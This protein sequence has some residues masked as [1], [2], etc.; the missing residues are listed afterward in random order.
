MPVACFETVMV[1]LACP[2]TNW[3]SLAFSLLL[4]EECLGKNTQLKLEMGSL[5]FCVLPF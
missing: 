1:L 2:L 4:A 3:A 5:S